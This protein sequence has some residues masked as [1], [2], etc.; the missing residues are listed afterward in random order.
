MWQLKEA[1]AGVMKTCVCL[2]LCVCVCVLPV[3]EH[4][5]IFT[6]CCC[7]VTLQVIKS[8]LL[9]VPGSMSLASDWPLALLPVLWQ[10]GSDV[11]ASPCSYIRKSKQS[12]SRLLGLNLMLVWAVNQITLSVATRLLDCRQRFSY[13]QTLPLNCPADQLTFAWIKHL[14][15]MEHRSSSK[16]FTTKKLHLWSA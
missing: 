1:D 13:K 6:L 3:A 15:C 4:E 8:P 14:I 11:F 2:C 9:P 12:K 5:L 10:D 7:A 16:C